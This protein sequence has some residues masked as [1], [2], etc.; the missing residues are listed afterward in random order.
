[1]T[2]AKAVVALR[3]SLGLNQADFAGRLETRAETVSRWENGQREPARDALERLAVLAAESGQK[4][5]RTFFV[6]KEV[7]GIVNRVRNLKSPGS[8]RHIA[9]KELKYWSAYLRDTS[10][11][12]NKVFSNIARLPE[13]ERSER[14]METARS[15]AHVM[16]YIR[17]RIERYVAEEDSTARLKE[18]KEILDWGHRQNRLAK[19]EQSE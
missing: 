12:A 5:L 11:N 4:H 8:E 15:M 6:A 10:R 1:M 18:D 2:T 14:A 16:D 17:D 3:E 7:A 9:L 19:G 13:K